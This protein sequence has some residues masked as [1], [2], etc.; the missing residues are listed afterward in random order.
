[1][2]MDASHPPPSTRQNYSAKY[3]CTE[4]PLQSSTARLSRYLPMDARSKAQLTYGNILLYVN[5]KSSPAHVCVC[6]SSHQK[7]IRSDKG[8]ILVCM[9]YYTYI[10]IVA[11]STA[12]VAY[13]SKYMIPPYHSI[14]HMVRP[15]N[16][17]RYIYEC[18][19]QECLRFRS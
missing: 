7:Q 2:H 16:G 15:A 18:V 12:V 5:P 13:T 10:R 11:I 8:V 3:C 1:M 9:S 6:V 14:D 19:I 17:D 4:V